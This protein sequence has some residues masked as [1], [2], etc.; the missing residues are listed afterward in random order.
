M[1]GIDISDHQGV[2]DWELLK[3]DSGVG[4]VIMKAMFE[5]G[6]HG[7]LNSFE[8]NYDGSAG[9]KR[10]AYLFTIAKSIDDA[11]KEAVDFVRIL[12][13][14]I[15]EYG[16]WLD[17]EDNRIARLGKAMLTQIID[18]QARIIR[19]AGYKVGIYSNPSWYLNVI[20]GKELSKRYE[21]WIA[22]YPLLDNGTI[23]PSKAPTA[24]NAKIW[25]FSSKGR[26]PGISVNCDLDVEMAD[27]AQ[28]TQTK[29][30]NNP[31]PVPTRNLK[32]GSKGKDVC[33]LQTALVS[34][35]YPLE[36]DGIFGD[37]TLDAVIRYQRNNK[38][39]V[40]GIVGVLTRNA[41]LK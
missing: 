16:V 11:Q 14:R 35:G 39:L 17:L 38:L 24:Y 18:A 7:K 8:R 32:R 20:D 40:D 31:F 3:R 4:F 21:M 2:I 36:I 30:N 34:K 13:G 29:P 6:K 5:N 9:L 33:W 41:L 37:N 10:G 15:L 19:D 23:K 12:N 1:K 25:Q 27:L 22:R 28:P 26:V